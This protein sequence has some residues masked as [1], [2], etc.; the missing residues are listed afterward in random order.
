M[1]E[2]PSDPF[3]DCWTDDDEAFAAGLPHH[4]CYDEEP[5]GAGFASGGMLDEMEAGPVLALLTASVTSPG[6]GGHAALGESELIGALRAWRRI[7]SWAAAGQ[8]AAITALARRRAAQDRRR[9]AGR[10]DGVAAAGLPARSRCG[11]VLAGCSSGGLRRA[12]TGCYCWPGGARDREERR[13]GATARHDRPGLRPAG[14]L[15]R[16]RAG[17]P[18][19]GGA[20]AGTDCLSGNSGGGRGDAPRNRGVSGRHRR[21]EPESAR[22]L[23]PD[24]PRRADCR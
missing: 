2:F 13:I 17:G 9:C 3:L 1:S 11:A 7:A 15:P 8:A 6:E 20:G 14:R 22:R 24:E 21:N 18:V 23:H 10:R 19:A 16:H 4:D 5:R 12:R